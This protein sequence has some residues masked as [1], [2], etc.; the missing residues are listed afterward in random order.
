M[1]GSGM[2]PAIPD[3]MTVLVDGYSH[4]DV[5]GHGHLVPLDRCRDDPAILTEAERRSGLVRAV[6]L[7]SEKENPFITAHVVDLCNEAIAAVR[8]KAARGLALGI[9]CHAAAKCTEVQSLAASGRIDRDGADLFIRRYCESIA[10]IVG[11]ITEN[12]TNI[13]GN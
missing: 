9:I 3:G 11:L 6:P 7:H 8:A 10:D 5:D 2:I 1:S 4:R 13:G 12:T